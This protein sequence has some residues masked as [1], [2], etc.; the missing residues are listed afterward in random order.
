MIAEEHIHNL[1]SA[2]NDPVEFAK[3]LGCVLPQRYKNEL[4][5]L[6]KGSLFVQRNNTKMAITVS[7][8]YCLWLCFMKNKVCTIVA[9]ESIDVISELHAYRDKLKSSDM[10]HLMPKNGNVYVCKLND[11][12]LRGR[13]LDAICLIGNGNKRDIEACMFSLIPTVI[14]SGSSG[15][16]YCVNTTVIRPKMVVTQHD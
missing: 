3:Y 6:S 12:H 15:R 7:V 9:D 16:L 4:R 10:Y 13:S 5:K 1:S 8:V 11:Y 14:T 2:A